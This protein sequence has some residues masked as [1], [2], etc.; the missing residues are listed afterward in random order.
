MLHKTKGIVFRYVKY[1]ET[2]IITNIYTEKFGLCG[3]IVN[4]VRSKKARNKIAFF[5][6]LT[7]LDLV[8]YHKENADISRIAE[9]KCSEPYEALPYHMQ[10]ST[11][12]MFLA[13]VLNKAIKES[14]GNTPL[15]EFLHHSLLMLDQLDK[16]YENFHL[17]FLLKLS[18]YLGFSVE[19]SVE[20]IEGITMDGGTHGGVAMVQ[21]L[22][23]TSYQEPIPMSNAQRRSILGGILK[24][25]DHHLNIG[26]VKSVEVLRDLLS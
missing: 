15:F 24:F 10:K 23:Q 5:Q 18:R 1:R 3:Y 2:S 22:V 19:S 14:E 20:E 17:R 21:A 4:G 25:Y 9:T 8:V 12:A 11:I 6:P 26:Q 13:E 7:L 16:G